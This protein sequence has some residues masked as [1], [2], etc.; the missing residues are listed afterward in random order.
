MDGGFFWGGSW[1]FLGFSRVF[2]G[3]SRVFWVFF[4]RTGVPES[5]FLQ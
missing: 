3:F 5:A 1:L 2:L 4:F